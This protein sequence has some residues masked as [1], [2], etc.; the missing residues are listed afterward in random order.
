MFRI[1]SILVVIFLLAQIIELSLQVIANSLTKDTSPWYNIMAI[2][3]LA[4]FVYSTSNMAIYLI[5]IYALYPKHTEEDQE[6]HFLT[7]LGYK[8]YEHLK[9]H[10]IEESG[11]A[12]DYMKETALAA[13]VERIRMLMKKTR[14]SRSII[15]TYVDPADFGFSA[16]D[17]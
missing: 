12:G 4:N 7:M 15:Q 2:H 10:L 9:D 13:T 1:H 14:F 6:V 5:V 17:F 16:Y 3:D 8:D 11:A